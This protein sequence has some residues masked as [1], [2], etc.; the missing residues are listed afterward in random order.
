MLKKRHNLTAIGMCKLL[1][2]WTALGW[3]LTLV[4]HLR[5]RPSLSH[6]MSKHSILFI[7]LALILPIAVQAQDAKPDRWEPVTVSASGDTTFI[8]TQS[9]VQDPVYGVSVWVEMRLKTPISDGAPRGKTY[10]RSV[11]RQT[12]DCKA[13]T[14]KMSSWTAYAKHGAV[15]ATD[16]T[17]IAVAMDRAIPPNSVLEGI[18]EAVCPASNERPQ[19]SGSVVNYPPTPTELFIPP[20]PVPAAV[21]GFHMIAQFDV[22]ETGKV[23][24][25]KFA[26]TR[27]SGYNRRLEEVLKGFKFRPGTK[28]DGTPIRMKAQI[29]YD[30]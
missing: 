12:Y 26:G 2:G 16:E 9:I 6:K 30:F 1:L 5:T 11:A 25:V 27:D 29:V 22:D 4:L 20:L 10:I 24:D 14:M 7:A 21:F 15:V 23:V 19:T 3:V 28:P 17:P 8:D 13:R 18:F